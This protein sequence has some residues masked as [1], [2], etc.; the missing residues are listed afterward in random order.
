[1]HFREIGLNIASGIISVGI[2][3]KLTKGDISFIIKS[4]TPEDLNAPIATNKPIKV[5]KSFATI[6]TP[7]F[8]PSKN[9]SKTL[10]LSIK[11]YTSINNIVIGIAKLDK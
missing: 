8:A 6:S 4:I 3:K 10:F 1:M 2:L 9:V 7:S 5:G 11:P